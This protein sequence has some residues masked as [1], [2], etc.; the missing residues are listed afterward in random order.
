MGTRAVKSFSLRDYPLDDSTHAI[1]ASG[2]LDVLVA[3]ELRETLIRLIE[4]GTTC[5]LV[6]LSET[7]FID[8]TAIGVLYGRLQELEPSGGSLSIVCHDANVLRT[9][10][11][12]GMDRAFAIYAT[13][14]DFAAKRGQA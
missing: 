8:S 14:D 2:E 9:F 1:E 7:T 10:Q 6:D 3:P 5:L 4:S 13:R 12:A 11:I